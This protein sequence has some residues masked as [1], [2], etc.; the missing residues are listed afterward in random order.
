MIAGLDEANVDFDLAE[1]RSMTIGG[2]SGR[3]KLGSS[4]T[5]ESKMSAA[6]DQHIAVLKF[7]DVPIF[8]EVLPIIE[9]KQI[10]ITKAN[11]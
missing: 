3:L 1:E 10:K 5:L 6:L 4:Y 7:G 8:S 2:T 9:I 11:C